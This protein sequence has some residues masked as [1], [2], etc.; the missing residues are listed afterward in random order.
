MDDSAL[1]LGKLAASSRFYWR[2]SALNTSGASEFSAS[3]WFETGTESDVNGHPVAAPGEFALGQNYPNPFNPMTTIEF[4]LPKE[5]FVELCVY[6]LLGRVAATLV[7]EELNAGKQQIQ[8]D[9]SGLESGSYLYRL[10]AGNFF[11]TKKM[12]LLK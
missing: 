6:D 4:S 2:V 10:Q 7:K 5:G 9:A 8:F 11:S 3:A 12:I 1:Q